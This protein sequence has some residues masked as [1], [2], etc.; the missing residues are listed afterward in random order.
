MQ[1][2]ITQ[3][4]MARSRVVNIPRWK[5]LCGALALAPL[6]LLASMAVYHFIFM[7]AVR[8][9][10]P[11]VTQVMRLIVHD[12][13][14]Q[15]ERFMRENL[16]AM[17][18]KVGEMQAK[19]VRL[20]SMSERVGHLAGLK[21]DEIDAL[22]PTP[23]PGGGEGGPF[24][25]ARRPSLE[26]LGQWVGGLDENADWTSDLFTI[27]EARLLQ[28]RLDAL[29]MPSQA[30]VDGHVGS[31]FGFRPDPFS[32]R[33][34]L[35]TGLDFPSLVGTPIVAAAGGVVRAS[36][37]HPEYGNMIEVDHGNGLVTRYAHCSRLLVKAGQVVRRGQAIGEVGT[38]GRSTG[39]HL[40]F[41]VL[42]DGAP[43][44]PAR[45]LASALTA[46]T[47]R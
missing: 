25:P 35:H 38:S 7:T 40:H 11:V 24:V 12:E 20:E 33:A 27:A 47:R 30:P 21:P 29:R 18:E 45:F 14:A 31:G 16:D 39:P 37:V 44:D 19:L 15:R 34:A 26:Q 17:A 5:L 9:G 2:L 22:R 8:E 36:E 43:Q 6:L 41:E 1:I 32:G 42:L 3:S 28:V 46:V 23:A 4:S 13:M 10:W